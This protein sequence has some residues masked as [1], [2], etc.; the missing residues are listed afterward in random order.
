MLSVLLMILAVLMIVELNGLQLTVLV[1]RMRCLGHF[2]MNLLELLI[3]V[4]VMLHAKMQYLICM[5]LLE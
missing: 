4:V 2:H 1:T 3:I 5:L